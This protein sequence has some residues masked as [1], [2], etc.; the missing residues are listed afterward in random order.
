MSLPLPIT[1]NLTWSKSVVD[2][3]DALPEDVRQ[4]YSYIGPAN[5]VLHVALPGIGGTTTSR[6]L[7]NVKGTWRGPRSSRF[8]SGAHKRIRLKNSAGNQS[9]V[10]NFETNTSKWLRPIPARP[11]VKN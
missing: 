2:I 11:P 9:V 8:A 10:M 4:C 7:Y 6:A 3:V 1:P 5:S